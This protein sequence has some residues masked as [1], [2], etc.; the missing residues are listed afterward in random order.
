MATSEVFH[1]QNNPE[2]LDASCMTHLDF[3]DCF[4]NENLRLMSEEIRCMK[5]KTSYCSYARPAQP[6]P[7]R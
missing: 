5:I 3:R 2:N 4:G 1:L 7:I 6:G